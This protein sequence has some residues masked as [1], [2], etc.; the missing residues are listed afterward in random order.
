MYPIITGIIAGITFAVTGYWK[1]K[2]EEIDWTKFFTT[3][4]L[5]LGIG[6]VYYF[7]GIEF[8][9]GLTY[10]TQLGA[11]PIIENLLKSV[12]RRLVPEETSS[13]KKK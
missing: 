10:L 12:W 4:L 7:T 1:S 5:G 13:K 3:V 8:G 9:L 6:V 11:V 2:G